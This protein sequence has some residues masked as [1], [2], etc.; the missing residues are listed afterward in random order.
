MKP[1]LQ[2]VNMSNEDDNVGYG[3]PPKNTRFGAKNG[4]PINRKG[5]KKIRTTLEDEI[6]A[7]FS[8]KMPVKV[9]GKS[10]PLSKRQ[11]ILEQVANGAVKGDPTMIKIALPFLK[12]MDD[13]PAFEPLPEDEA[14]LKIFKE[15]FSDDGN[16]KQ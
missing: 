14:I 16:E 10:V 4:N 6:K 15:Q 11:I 8:A 7:V 1:W 5:R 13:A 3:K 12:T 2:E 9:D